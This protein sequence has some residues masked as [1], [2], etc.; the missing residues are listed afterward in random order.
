MPA[1][2]VPGKARH[3]VSTRNR[4][5]QRADEPHACARII[6]PPVMDCILAFCL[7]ARNVQHITRLQLCSMQPMCPAALMSAAGC[8]HLPGKP[9]QD[10]GHD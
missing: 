8:K 3:C 6:R 1:H 10:K 2:E 7:Y 9:S 4:P 5:C